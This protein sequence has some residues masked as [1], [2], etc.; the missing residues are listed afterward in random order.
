M[1]G[2]N[3]LDKSCS[4]TLPS[5]AIVS[6]SIQYDTY[7]ET[8]MIRITEPLDDGLSKKFPMYDKDTISE[9]I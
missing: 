2:A 7:V 4:Y 1:F 5:T 6:Y 3:N 8:V 9:A